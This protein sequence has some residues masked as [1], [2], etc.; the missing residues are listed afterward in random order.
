MQTKLSAC[1]SQFLLE[2]GTRHFSDL[3]VVNC[4]TCLLLVLIVLLS[5]SSPCSQISI[6][7][8]CSL[9]LLPSEYKQFSLFAL[10]PVVGRYPLTP[11]FSIV[12]DS[13][14]AVPLE[15]HLSTRLLRSHPDPAH[16][17]TNNYLNISLKS[18]LFYDSHSGLG[19]VIIVKIN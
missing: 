3:I 15:Q 11:S 13:C 18:L 6:L 9:Q 17:I 4:L 16:Y 1:V 2:L 14:P 7:V 8:L 5:V 12:T 10:S 19:H